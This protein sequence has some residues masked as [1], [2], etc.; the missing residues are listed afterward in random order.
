M[1]GS[2]T[3]GPEAAGAVCRRLV[4]IGI[5]LA[6]E[7]ELPAVL[8]RVLGEARG[9]T[10]AEAGTIFL[11][12]GDRLRF[13]A[14]HNDVLADEL[15]AT[16]MKR[17]LEGVAMTVSGS[18]LVGY[19]ATTGQVLRVPDVD[20][21]PPGAPYAFD[22]SVDRQ[23]TYR[24]RSV[25]AVPLVDHAGESLG[26]LEL[27]N[28]RNRRAAITDF[29]PERVDLVR[30]LAAQAT[31]SVRAA[32]LEELSYRD[33]L[34]GL[35]NRRYFTLRVQEEGRRHDRFAEPLSLVLMDIDHFKPVNDRL[36]HVA[37]DA[38]LREV[39]QLL[40][41]HSRSDSVITRYGGDEFAVLLA[42]TSK[43]GAVAY[44]CRIKA[45]VEAHPFAHGSLTV[46]LGVSCLPDDVVTST[47]LVAA[48]DRA[49]YLAKRAG[50]NG[51]EGA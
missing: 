31:L 6:V 1:T 44:A 36:G 45:L 13:A 49:L 22:R 35:Y 37:G 14:V 30:C 43:P 9:F 25:L 50:R 38:L 2:R 46:S 18:S 32:L 17:R 21:I 11:R 42:N 10:G 39:G 48:A 20:A 23:T 28:A 47:D 8:D 26:V 5:A 16:E 19:V 15:G 51:V 12:E 27:M 3:G 41:R 33:P 24:T 7:P 4:D 34:T 29:A 40:A